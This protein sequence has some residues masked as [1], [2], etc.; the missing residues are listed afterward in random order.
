MYSV[1][2]DVKKKYAG[3]PTKP[4]YKIM[5]SEINDRVKRLFNY[6]VPMAYICNDG[7][8]GNGVPELSGLPD[9]ASAFYYFR[10]NELAGFK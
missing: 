7:I 5:D 8:S 9:V 1:T 4:N 2:K 10:T 6:S 3:A